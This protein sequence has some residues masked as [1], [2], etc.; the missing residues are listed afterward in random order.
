MI[1]LNNPAEFPLPEETFKKHK[2]IRYAIYQLEIGKEGTP[3]IQLY[4]E[5][6]KPQRYTALMKIIGN[7][8]YEAARTDREFC[9]AYCSKEESRLDG[10]YEYGTW[11]SGAGSKELVLPVKRAREGVSIDDIIMECPEEY[12]RMRGTV[13]RARAL[14]FKDQWKASFPELEL[15]QW[16][17]EVLGRLEGP[18]NDREV[19]W[20]YGPNGKEGKSTFLKYL[21]KT[22]NAFYVNGGNYNDIAYMYDFEEIVC[23]DCSR[24]STVR[25]IY[26]I[27]EKFKDGMIFSGKYEACMK[28][29]K[30]PH[31]IVAA[32]VEADFECIS[33][34]RVVLINL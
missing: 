25:N 22:K 33:R 31:V 4:V 2:D 34:D 9:K 26:E 11:I 21:V 10:P 6:F 14:F 32:N 12:N 28:M 7:G 19:I 29:V 13:H 17:I 3:H 5:L 30:S 8:H 27:I 20:L 1:T 15:R 24:A 18:A 16:Q 23:F